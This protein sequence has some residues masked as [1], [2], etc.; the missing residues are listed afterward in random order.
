[1]IELKDCE[2]WN[3][4]ER[5]AALAWKINTL[6]WDIKTMAESKNLGDD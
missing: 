3:N 2:K 6:A 1:M 5:A 4:W